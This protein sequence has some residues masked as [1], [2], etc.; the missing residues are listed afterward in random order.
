MASLAVVAVFAMLYERPPNTAPPD[1]HGCT[2]IEVRW[3]RGILAHPVF[4]RGSRQNMLS[5]RERAYLQS[6]EPYVVSNPERLK[7]F[8]HNM[9][10]GTYSRR[11]RGTPSWSS[12]IHVTCYRDTQRLTS[13]T[14]YGDTIIAEDGGM[15]KYPTYVAELHILEPPQIRPFKLRCH[16]ALNLERLQ[17]AGPL[18]QKKAHKYP[19]SDRW[20]DA[21]VEALGKRAVAH[22][23]IV[24]LFRCPGIS[25]Y[26]QGED[27]GRRLGEPDVTDQTLHP[28]E[29]H[30]AMNATCTRDSPPD[31]VLLFE[32]SSGWN[33]HGGPELFAFDQHKPRGGC[34]LLNDGTVT[35]IRTEEELHQLRC[36]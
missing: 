15:F 4:Y 25:G 19:A 3:P 2:R 18:W 1:L 31:M 11:A 17:G 8:A 23:R 6:L 30:Y 13:F 27:S 20:C 14:I 10:E 9:D 34:V 28:W 35:F 12:P 22:E 7:A 16:C 24:R 32:A 36:K 21:V 5:A 26:T 29:S 33:Q